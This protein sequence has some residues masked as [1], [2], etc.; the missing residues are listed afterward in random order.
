[1]LLGDFGCRQNVRKVLTKRPPIGTSG[2]RI[3]GLPRILER[4]PEL[5]SSELQIG[6]LELSAELQIGDLELAAELQ[7]GALRKALNRRSGARSSSAQIWL[8]PAEPSS[9]QLTAQ[10]GPAPAQL[11]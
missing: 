8:N 11:R 5:I 1:M 2:A 10:R 7:I 6:A 4:N 9:A 3:L